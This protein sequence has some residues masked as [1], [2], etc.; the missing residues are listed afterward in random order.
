MMLNKVTFT[1]IV[2]IILALGVRINTQQHREDFPD[3]QVARTTLQ[4][5]VPSM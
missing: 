5:I 4:E 1:T 3:T 2:F